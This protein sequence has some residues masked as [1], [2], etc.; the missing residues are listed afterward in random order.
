MLLLHAISRRHAV[1]LG[2]VALLIGALAAQAAG[3]V[4]M[5][6]FEELESRV[7]ELELE[8]TKLKAS[9]E[10]D[11][12]RLENLHVQLTKAEETLRR[13]GANLGLRMERVEQDLA[14]VEGEV[15]ALTFRMKGLNRSAEILK[16][17]IAERLGAT[18]VFLPADLPEDAEGVWR[19][20]EE[21]ERAERYPEARAVFDYFEASF[22]DDPRAPEALVRLARLA[23]QEG[24]IGGAIE[25][26][27]RVADQYVDSDQAPEALWR[28]G[29]L[30]AA[31]GD[32][33]RA[34]SIFG[35]LEKEYGDS[36]AAGRADAEAADVLKD[37]RSN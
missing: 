21:L 18:S 30:L 12:K 23:E 34:K 25:L 13:S 20:G 22:S 37:C 16:R 31:R 10:E 26:Y 27:R 36:E 2:G 7:A 35:Y 6:R 11:V 5:G 8:R 14:E 28:I 15:E 32:C 24:D 29:E 19:R 33:K 4:T 3:C 1:R 17:V 9:M